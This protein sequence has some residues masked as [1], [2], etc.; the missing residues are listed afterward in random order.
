MAIWKRL[1]ACPR[2]HDAFILVS[3]EYNS[4]VPPLLKN[5][6]DWASRAA[7]GVSGAVHYQGK[8]V[9]LT[10]ATPGGLG[11]LRGLA[12]WRQIFA[13]LGAIVMPEQFPLSQADKA[14]DEQGGFREAR[15]TSNLQG[16]LT[17]FAALAGKL[18]AAPRA[19]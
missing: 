14:F 8:L 15:H 16:L 7:D 12:Q 3:P 18:F 13:G 17:R 2:A 9:L 11:G 5:A 19:E 10:A 4:S 6:I 1:K